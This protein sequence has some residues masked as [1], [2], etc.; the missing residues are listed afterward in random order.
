[1]KLNFLYQIAAASRLGGYSPQIP[2]LSVLCHQ[3]NLLNIT[4]KKNSWIRHCSEL[5]LRC[6]IQQAA[7]KLN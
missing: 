2:I 5:R 1:M 4:P 7:H 6:G 3:L